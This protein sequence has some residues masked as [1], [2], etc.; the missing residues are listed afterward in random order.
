VRDGG[1]PG[2]AKEDDTKGE[3]DAEED[4]DEEEDQ[5]EDEDE[6]PFHQLLPH[7]SLQLDKPR[8][9]WVF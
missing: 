6:R 7:A 1:A 9:R 8:L 2:A 3:E 4:E 5:D